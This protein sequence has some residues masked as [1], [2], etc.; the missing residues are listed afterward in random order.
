MLP[1]NRLPEDEAVPGVHFLDKLLV[2]AERYL[3][4]SA[5]FY[6]LLV[7]TFSGPACFH[8]LFRQMAKQVFF[9][10]IRGVHILIM[11][12][13]MLGLQM[14]LYATEQLIKVSYEEF[15]G[16][17]LVTIVVRE[18]GPILAGAFILVHSGSAII[19][20][21]G[22]MSVSREIEAL[23]ITGVDPYRYLGVPRFWGVTISAICLYIIIIIFA[24]LGGCVFA[25]F[26][27]DI[28][29]RRIWHFFNNALEGADLVTGLVK[30]TLFGM[31]IATVSIFAGFE[32]RGDMGEVA[33]K[34][35]QAAL[36]SLVLCGVMDIIIMNAYYL[37]PQQR[38]VSPLSALASRLLC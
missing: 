18:L 24:V 12:A 3:K 6:R 28:D 38:S 2:D 30:A 9:T 17:L 4:I 1:I 34:T 21:L 26:Y 13:L 37:M 15:V 29:W 7:A 19:V 14:I 11:A 25:Q 20:E 23:Q 22:T 31:I 27:T 16:W 32:A 10:A 5:V 35:A 36:W 8:L 33:N